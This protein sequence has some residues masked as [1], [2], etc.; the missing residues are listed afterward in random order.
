MMGMRRVGLVGMIVVE[1]LLTACRG[2]ARGAAAQLP[3]PTE[4]AQWIALGVFVFGIWWV[5]MK[6]TRG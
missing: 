5:A 6:I 2:G 3:M 4:P 1:L